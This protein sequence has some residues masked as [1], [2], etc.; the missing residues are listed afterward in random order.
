MFA[1]TASQVTFLWRRHYNVSVLQFVYSP[2][3]YSL[4]APES[5]N[6]GLGYANG[7]IWIALGWDPEG[8][9]DTSPLGTEID[10]C[11]FCG[12]PLSGDSPK[13]PST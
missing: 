6:R 8:D 7:P 9:N 3:P 2:V 4:H 11:P 1:D 10:F 5:S 12:Y 13:G